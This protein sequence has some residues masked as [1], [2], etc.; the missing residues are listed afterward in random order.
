MLIGASPLTLTADLAGKSRPPVDHRVLPCVYA[1]S[2]GVGFDSE[3]FLLARLPSVDT[4]QAG[5]SGVTTGE[6]HGY[7]DG[8]R[9]PGS[10]VPPAPNNDT[11]PMPPA[12]ASLQGSGGAGGMQGFGVKGVVT[13][14]VSLIPPRDGRLVALVEQRRRALRLF[15]LLERPG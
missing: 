11:P 7:R 15:F 2:A 3:R 5:R 14:R 13:A 1:V 6:K 8:S 4:T 10:P 9:K 12:P